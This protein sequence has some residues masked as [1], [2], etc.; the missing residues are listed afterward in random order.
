MDAPVAREGAEILASGS[1]SGT[2]PAGHRNGAS[3]ARFR[4]IASGLEGQ[5]R[6]ARIASTL[7]F[8]LFARKLCLP[9]PARGQLGDCHLVKHH[10]R[11]VPA[12][13]R[14]QGNSKDLAQNITSSPTPAKFSLLV[15]CVG[16]HWQVHAGSR[17]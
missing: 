5:K 16:D 10:I 7:A 15:I 1:A 4:L 12:G 9:R 3:L 14:I 2:I 11:E 8:K 6:F 17:I 13:A